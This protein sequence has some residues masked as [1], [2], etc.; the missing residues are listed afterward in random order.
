VLLCFDFVYLVDIV[1]LIDW[2]EK[3]YHFCE[4]GVAGICE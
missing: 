3:S 4:K 2:F 1:D